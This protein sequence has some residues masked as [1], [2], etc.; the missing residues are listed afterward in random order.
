[1]GLHDHE[2]GARVRVPP[3]LVFLVFT[4]LGVALRYVVTPPSV[5]GDRVV[6]IV[7][8]AGLFVVGLAFVLSARV[9]FVR[10]GQNPAPWKPSPELIVEGPY[11]FTR[12]PMYVG[13]TLLD[14]GLGLAV[15]N[16]WI[17]SFAIPALLIVHI[18]VVLPQE[19]Y[20]ET[21]FGQSY[22]AYRARVRRYL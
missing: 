17:S 6:T 5:P 14:V 22:R 12:N 18:F 15:H 21:K 11:R 10:T 2:H 16:L 13:L 8:G 9:L 3:P 4:L 7:V 20:L 19:R 1:M